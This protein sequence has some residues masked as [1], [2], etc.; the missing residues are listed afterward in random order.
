MVLT[1][2]QSARLRSKSVTAMGD[3]EDDFDDEDDDEDE[4]IEEELGYY[5]P[6]DTVNPY[7]T[8]QEALATFQAKNGPAFQTATTSLTM[9]QQT[10]LMEIARIAENP[11]VA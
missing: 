6:L 4:E 7:T 9:E 1:F 5:S 2:R 11:S 10:T 8:F 3:D